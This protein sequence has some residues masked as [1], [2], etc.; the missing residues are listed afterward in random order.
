MFKTLVKNDYQELSETANSYIRQLLQEKPA[1]VIG[2]AT[3]SSP[4]GLYGQM[5]TDCE[6]QVTSYQDV[7]TF[8]LDEYIGL[9]KEHPESYIS[10]MYKNLFDHVDIKKENVH[11]PDAKDADDLAACDE[12]EELM[13]KYQ[14]DIQVL[15]IGSN[16]HIGFNEPGTDFDSLTHIVELT[17]RTR[18]D[19]QRFFASLDEVPTHAI[20]MGIAT[21]LKAKKIVLVANGANKAQAVFDMINGPATQDV[22]ASVL[23]KHPDVVVI[24][25][26]DAAGKL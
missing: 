14:V 19:N 3:G 20:T 9:P 8:N 7:V 25:D 6:N 21:I 22:P 23:Q 18:L 24:L 10:F 16:G 4:L 11:L 5:I 1:A 15:G 26:K 2:L 13:S 17:K 12:Y